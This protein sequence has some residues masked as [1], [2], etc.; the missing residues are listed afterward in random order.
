VPAL[1]GQVFLPKDDKSPGF[2]DENQKIITKNVQNIQ[3]LIDNPMVSIYT[4]SVSLYHEEK[5][6]NG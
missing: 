5:C 3:F 4:I 2:V 1:Q 6:G